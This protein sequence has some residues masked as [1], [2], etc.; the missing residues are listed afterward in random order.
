[1]SKHTK[2]LMLKLD[3]ELSDTESKGL[4]EEGGS[5][6]LTRNLI[7]NAYQLNNQTMGPKVAKQWR[8]VRKLLQEAVEET[9][10]G[11]VI[12]SSSDFDSIYDEVYKCK[13]NPSLARLAP[14]LYDEL[15]IVKQRSAEDEEK[16]Q[17][18]MMD[19]KEAVE[20]SKV[21]PLSEGE[22]GLVNEKLEELV[23][24]NK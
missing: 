23:A 16:V 11:F 13:F 17:E 7:N 14:Y 12:L 5:A 1:M 6:V 19:L 21:E 3:Y 24:A 4:A 18:E 22:Q 8:S 10:V 2:L 15:D 9:K 20:D